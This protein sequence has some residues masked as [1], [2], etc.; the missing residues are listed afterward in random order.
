MRWAVARAPTRL[1]SHKLEPRGAVLYAR[2]MQQHRAAW[3]VLAAAER[4]CWDWDPWK[5]SSQGRLLAHSTKRDCGATFYAAPCQTYEQPLP[6]T[7]M[8][9][10]I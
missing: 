10:P 7:M 6:P 9:G 1:H 4:E 5:G 8:K 3:H 2:S